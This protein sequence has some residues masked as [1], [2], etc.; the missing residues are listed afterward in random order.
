VHEP[1]AGPPESDIR[2]SLAELESS[3]L[4]DQRSI[5]LAALMA[6][7][8]AA[9]APTMPGGRVRGWRFSMAML[10]LRL[11]VWI[12]NQHARR[13]S[14]RAVRIWSRASRT[15][16]HGGPGSFYLLR[17]AVGAL[18]SHST[19][20]NL[21][22]GGHWDNTGVVE[23]IRRRCA[24]IVCIDAS[25]EA[26][27]RLDA[28]SNAISLARVVAGAMID[29]DLSDLVAA[30]GVVARKAIATGTVRYADGTESRLT[31]M[32]C[33]LTED[34]P[35][36]LRSRPG[37]DH[38]FPHHPTFMQFF[39]ADT[40]EAYRALGEHVASEL[41]DSS[42]LAAAVPDD[43]GLAR[44]AQLEQSGWLRSTGRPAA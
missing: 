13:G 3:G 38:N 2:M 33:Q 42:I 24:H 26:P 10:N 34:T 22:D 37:I 15:I 35:F 23:L 20:L 6:I 9:I 29:I 7:S 14:S 4:A 43:G 41:V 21:T 31:F 11:G 28:I 44:R 19:F 12:R 8:G 1:L 5:D 27:G 18:K 17:E 30:D 39:D 16:R 36:D 40:I 25:F 32:R